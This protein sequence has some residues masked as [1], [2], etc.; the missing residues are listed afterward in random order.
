MSF[1]TD[2]TIPAWITRF[3][4]YPQQLRSQVHDYVNQLAIQ[5]NVP[6]VCKHEDQRL[7][8]IRECSRFNPIGDVI[9]RLRTESFFP[10]R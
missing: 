8:L 5:K 1:A 2:S 10:I 6:V 4:H 3:T 7:W 9:V